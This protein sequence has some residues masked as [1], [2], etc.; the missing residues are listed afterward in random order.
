MTIKQRA[1]SAVRWT[2]FVTI[3]R[4]VLQT[5]QLVVLARLISPQDFGLMA[6][7][8]SVTAFIQLFSDLGVS[9]SII[10]ARYISNE[11]LSTLYWL[12][13]VIG[14]ALSGLIWLASPH[15]A[16][17]YSEPHLGRPL[18]LAGLSFLLLAI[19]QQVKVLAEKRLDFQVV[20]IVELAS[21]IVATILTIVAA[22]KGAGVYALVIGVLSMSGGNS[23]LYLL[24]ARKG[25]KPGLAM[26]FEE[27]LPH[28]KAG[29][30]LLGTSLANTATV[31]A[32]VIIVGR[33]LGSVA[34]G[35]Y[36]LPRDLC[37]KVMLA[38][39]PV[40]T[41]VG[42]PLMAEAQNDRVLLS[43]V[44]M[45]TIRMT[46]SINFPIYGAIAVFCHEI[47]AVVFGPNWAQSANLLGIMAIWGMFRSLGNPV[48][49]LL[50]GT[51][52]MRLAF[53]QSLAVGLLIIP[54]IYLGAMWD[55]SGV[56]WALVAFYFV[57]ASAIWV[58]VVGP[59]TGA[60]FWTYTEQWLTPLLVTAVACATAF[61]VSRPIDVLLL[62]LVI[63]LATG[64]IAYL[65]ISWFLN[66]R[67]CM[68]VLGV[69]FRRHA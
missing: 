66:R 3:A 18:S 42:T 6:M 67:W 51:G 64:G 50:Y 26:N 21:V 60:S 13:V 48:G 56:V 2:A 25:W 39:N 30:F 45:S 20:A 63:G 52:N 54:T 5:L 62:R 59:I 40:I 1:F 61:A 35:I 34:L 37:L 22:Y 9:N 14:G 8:L 31:Q 47:T 27:A 46:S 19:G 15:I 29:L 36:T 53:A 28:L 7:V 12:N 24:F 43:K 38:T 4:I 57:F 41:R 69:A 32:D 65:A 49:S 17:F 11:G 68:A 10:H 58:F 23:L 44:Y 33:L 16:A 55:T